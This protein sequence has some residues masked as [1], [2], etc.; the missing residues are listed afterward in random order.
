MRGNE[1]HHVVLF[2]ARFELKVM[3]LQRLYQPHIE[4]AH[5]TGFLVPVEAAA[6]PGR[7]CI[8]SLT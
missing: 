7:M 1:A 6:Q 3:R 4:P 5:L 2:A 8:P